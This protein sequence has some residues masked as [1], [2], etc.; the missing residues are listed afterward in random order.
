M[1]DEAPPSHPVSGSEQSKEGACKAVI[2]WKRYQ[3]AV[4]HAKDIFNAVKEQA[5]QAYAAVEVPARKQ[6]DYQTTVAYE[7]FLKVQ[8]LAWKCFRETE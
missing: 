3:E 8:R 6:R 7:E 5:D 4:D 2:K 1:T